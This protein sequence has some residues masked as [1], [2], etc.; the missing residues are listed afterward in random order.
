MTIEG[1]FRKELMAMKKAVYYLKVSTEE[2]VKEGKM[3]AGRVWLVKREDYEAYINGLPSN[4]N[5]K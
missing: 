3:K 2:Q 5:G 4:R 1:H